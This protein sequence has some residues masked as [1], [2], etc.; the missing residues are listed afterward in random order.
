MSVGVT[1]ACPVCGVRIPVV[2]GAGRCPKCGPVQVLRTALFLPKE[3]LTSPAPPTDVPITRSTAATPRS[4]G[5][6]EAQLNGLY[7]G[8]ALGAGGVILVGM[9]GEELGEQI[10]NGFVGA[11]IGT[12]AGLVFGYVGAKFQTIFPMWMRENGLLFMLLQGSDE[13]YVKFMTVLGVIGGILN[14]FLLGLVL[15]LPLGI[16]LPVGALGAALLVGLIASMLARFFAELKS[17]DEHYQKR[18]QR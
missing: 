9:F 12:V 6:R 13:D 16:A 3:E 15:E 8:A 17:A 7:A 18:H 1:A 4:N 10:A 11:L 5:P 2:Q 14:G